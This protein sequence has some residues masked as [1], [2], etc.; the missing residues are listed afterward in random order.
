LR[1]VADGDA[2]D[3][4]GWGNYFERPE[5]EAAS[6]EL[7]VRDRQLARA[8]FAAAPQYDVEVEHA[9]APS[10][11]AAPTEIAFDAL[12][13]LQHLG[14]LE[15]AFDERHSIREITPRAAMGSVED[16]W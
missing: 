2:S 11:A 7:G 15:T 8:E 14:R 9:R 4:P 13:A 3:A 1:E 5:D 16:D 12:E 6:G 10:A